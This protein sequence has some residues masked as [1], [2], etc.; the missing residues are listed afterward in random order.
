[1]KSFIQARHVLL[2]LLFLSFHAYAFEPFVVKDIRVEGLQRISAGTVFNYLPVSVG[3]VMD[4][5]RARESI[6]A[7]FK[8]GFFKDV[9]L[10]REGDTLI[11]RV[12]ER[13]AI[14]RVSISGNREVGTDELK[15][16]LEHIGLAPG[17]VFKRALLEN[18]EQ[19]LKNLYFSLGKYG[20]QIKTTVTPV[21]RNRVDIAIQIREGEVARIRAIHLVGN[22]VFSDKVL[23]KRFQ[24]HPT[25][26]LSFWKKDDRYSKQKLTADLEA[27][28]SFY[29]D[30]GYLQFR[31][32]NT[33]VSLTPDKKGVYITIEIEEGDRYTVKDVRLEGR[34]VLPKDELKSL[35]SIHPGDVFSRR[36]VTE[37]AT[38][39]G[40]RL[41]EE[42]YAFA[43]INAIPEV[44]QVQKQVSLTFFID[45]GKRTYVRRIQITGNT[46]TEDEVLRREMRQMESALLKTKKLE[47]SRTRLEKL[48]Y[49]EEVNV[50]TPAVAGTDDQVDVK[51]NVT[52]RPSGN[53][54]AGLGFSQSQGII[55][56]ASVT[57]DN[58][59]GT[60]KRVSVAFNN[61]QVNRVY[62]F[63]YNNPYYTMDGVSRGFSLYYR[64]TDSGAANVGDFTTDVAG[65]NLRYGIPLKEFDTL[66][67]GVEYEHL[68][69]NTTD[70]TPQ[71]YI[72]FIEENGDTFD[73]PKLTIGWSHDSRNRALFPEKGT[74][75][76]LSLEATLPGVGLEYYKLGYRHQWY[77][78][79]IKHTILLL[80]GQLGYGDSF[81]G[82]TRFPFFENFYAGGSRTVRGFK[83][84]T[85]GPRSSNNN[86]LGGSVKVVGNAEL[87]FPP[88]LFTDSKSV[89]MG[90]FFDAGNVFE[91]GTFDAGELR[92]SVGFSTQWLSPL[93]P[94]SFSLAKALNAKGEDETQVFQFAIGTA[95]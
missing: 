23:L 29:L 88:P 14:A 86:P 41:A 20:V 90:I 16:A 77:R 2:G 13:P 44:D 7:L 82:T 39:L 19:E 28:R 12:V 32:R 72:T 68:S 33:L 70:S 25:G 1:M 27:L 8:T 59:L 37:S 46:K 61:S 26:W 35:I 53:L 6:R 15:K 81:G 45:P 58:F 84:N 18:V 54:L 10:Y 5:Q 30:Q 48:G 49:F 62:S 17:R 60:G 65:G 78:P 21:E 94:L 40:E 75:A 51:F 50:E 71:E 31:I 80:K 9:R 63:A 69:V 64:T 57:Q 22:R 4:E 66:R 93:G 3:E 67:F 42:G 79:L 11:V 87:L 47:L 76:S 74:L 38:R 55:F 24:L 83:D 95:F 91:S 52:E 34:F 89:R 43:N 36:E 56:N 85:L 73:V 92:Y